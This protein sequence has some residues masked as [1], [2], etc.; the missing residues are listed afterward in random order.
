MCPI[1]YAL[2][3]LVTQAVEREGAFGMVFGTID[4]LAGCSTG[5]QSFP[6][7]RDVQSLTDQEVA[8]TLDG[9]ATYMEGLSK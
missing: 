3:R 5:D 8:D 9:L 4:W 6:K 7:G 2:Q 1:R